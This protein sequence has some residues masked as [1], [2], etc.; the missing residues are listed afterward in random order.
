MHGRP[1]LPGKMN[2][3]RLSKREYDGKLMNFRISTGPIVYLNLAGQNVVVL[4]TLEV[5]SDLLDDR[6]AIYSDRPNWI[7]ACQMLTEG[8]FMPFVRY[9]ET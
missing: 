9:G 3:V 6:A 5:A 4:N 1:S 7:V 2:T 8:L